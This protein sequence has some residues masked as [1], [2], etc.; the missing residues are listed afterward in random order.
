MKIIRNSDRKILYLQYTNPTAY[1]PLEHSSRILA[2]NDWQVLFLGIGA[3]GEANNLLFASHPNIKLRQISSCPPGWRQKLHYIQFCLWVWAWCIYWQPK[4]VYASDLFS[5]PMALII[6]F[7][8]G[9]RVIYHEHDTNTIELS[10]S[11][12]IKLCFTAR[13]WLGNRVGISVLP[14]QQRLEL[15]LRETDNKPQTICVWN[16]PATEEISPPPPSDKFCVRSLKLVYHGSIN[17]SRLPLSIL[18]A[19]KKLGDGITLSIIGYETIGHSNYVQ[20]LTEKA[21]SLEISDRLQFL[22]AIPLRH[23][24]LQQLQQYDLGLAFMPKNSNDINL[25]HML[26]A[27]NKPFDYLSC[28]LALLVSDL[29]DWHD[30]YVGSGYGLSCNPDNVNSIAAALRWCLEHPTQMRKMGE[31][32]R[33]KIAQEWNY[34]QQF[35]PVLEL[36]SVSS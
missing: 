9:V 16:C 6:S 2:R 22:G 29:P 31:L 30:V 26:G 7:V 3:Q 1:P 13:K 17:P 14:N 19:I 25:Q 15:Y 10:S 33:Q 12:F 4:V 36:I 27:S 34:E 35:K 8:P 21:E 32:G 23:K 5:C 20:Q 28:G 24:L 18:D 11:L